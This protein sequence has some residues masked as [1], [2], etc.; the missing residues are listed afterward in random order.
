M[1]D[2]A[3]LDYLANLERDWLVAQ[4]GTNTAQ[5]MWTKLLHSDF[6]IYELLF[7]FLEDRNLTVYEE[8]P[9]IA[10]I[11]HVEELESEKWKPVPY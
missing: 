3:D 11:N 8:N 9:V 5:K 6:L 10:V 2:P 4:K 1:I 7:E